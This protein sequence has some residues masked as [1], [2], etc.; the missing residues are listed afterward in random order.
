MAMLDLMADIRRAGA[1]RKPGKVLSVRCDSSTESELEIE[2]ENLAGETLATVT[3]ARHD[4]AKTLT[5]AIEKAIG[6]QAL[7][8][9]GSEVNL[10]LTLPDGSVLDLET[11]ISLEEIFD[12][13]A[14]PGQ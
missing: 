3:T 7:R 12:V 11:E 6:F 13:A 1:R 14:T 8:S 5:Q 9:D 10:K 4:T 2:V